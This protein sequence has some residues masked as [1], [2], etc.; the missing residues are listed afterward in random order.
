MKS[1]VKVSIS[2]S[3]FN[4]DS[5]AYETLCGYLDR[6]EKHFSRKK[7][8]R[9]IVSD[10]EER[11]AELLSAR[12]STPD[13][14]VSIALVEEVI[15]I[16][17]MPGDMEDGET[18][19]AAAPPPQSRKKRLYRDVSNKMLGGVCSG[20]AAYFNIDLAFSRL[21][22]VLFFVM[23]FFIRHSVFGVSWSVLFIVYIVLWIV[24][25]P[26]LTAREKAEMHGD[27]TTIAGIQKKVE[28]EIRALRRKWERKGKQWTPEIETEMLE[29][30]MAARR[31]EHALTRLLRLALR[32]VAVFVGVIFLIVAVCGLVA[33]PVVIFVNT[34]VSNVVELYLFDLFDL[35]AININPMLFKVLLSAVLLLPLL[36]LLYLG[37]KAIVGFRDRF[38]TGLIMFL[39]WLA[40]GVTLAILASSSALGFRRWTDV[41]E[42]VRVPAPYGTLQVDVPAPYRDVIHGDALL[43]EYDGNGA[44]F[45]ES[46]RH[47]TVKAYVL[48]DIDVVQ[49]SDTGSIRVCFIKTASGLTRAVARARAREV[50]LNYTL[51][52]SLLLIEPFVYSRAH[53]WAGEVMS[54]KIYVPQGKNV[55]NLINNKVGVKYV[56]PL[57]KRKKSCNM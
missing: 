13:Q 15:G 42:E 26:A 33:F 23:L 36:G 38:R 28:G 57:H 31:R 37:I 16:M 12:I 46:S 25:P 45:W 47:G 21:F 10:I 1:T 6:L 34:A 7:G 2:R 30:S 8:G 50:P 44:V 52:D 49:T 11:I 19:Y 55:H 14:V 22:F 32:M 48:P 9:E 4:L 17:G 18:D 56:F 39:L 20:L 51:R 53:K 43:F 54:V 40:A 35:V 27:T 24:I 41:E 29:A 3:A 5:D